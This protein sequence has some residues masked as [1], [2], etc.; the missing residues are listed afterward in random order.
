MG[1][2]EYD[3]SRIQDVL[4]AAEEEKIHRTNTYAVME[5]AEQ[6]VDDRDLCRVQKESRSSSK[7][8]RLIV[9]SPTDLPETVA[10]VR[11]HEG[12]C[13]GEHLLRRCCG[14][15]TPYQ[16]CPSRTVLSTRTVELGR[17]SPEVI[18]ESKCR[19]VIGTL[20][21]R[22]HRSHSNSAT[23]LV[24]CCVV[25]TPPQQPSDPGGGRRDGSRRRF[26]ARG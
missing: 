26:R 16:G 3:G 24:R 21:H 7:N 20:G 25:Y 2:E 12:C 15:T 23:P 6:L 8:T 10:G 4:E 22:S 18:Q 14:Y 13:P 19:L 5:K 11:I 1:R 9:K 17:K